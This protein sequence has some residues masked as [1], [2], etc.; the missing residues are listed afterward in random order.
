MNKNE[1]FEQLNAHDKVIQN[2]IVE[3][4]NITPYY[5]VVAELEN[6]Y[7]VLNFTGCNETFDKYK[8]E[9]CLDY[10]TESIKMSKEDI[11]ELLAKIEK[12]RIHFMEHTL[13]QLKHT[14]S[15]CIVY[16]KYAYKYYCP[17]EI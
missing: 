9:S 14:S 3:Y 8:K 7:K 5:K 16:L 10:I 2:C 13:T 4:K 12:E 1:I 17:M 11:P 15:Q 6:I